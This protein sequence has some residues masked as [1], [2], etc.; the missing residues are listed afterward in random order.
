[1]TEIGNRLGQIYVYLGVAKC[2]LLQKEFDKVF[3][4]VFFS[5]YIFVSSTYQSVSVFLFNVVFS[6]SWLFAASAGPGR[7]NRKQGIYF[8]S[9]DDK[10]LFCVVQDLHTTSPCPANNVCIYAHILAVYSKGAL[11]V[12]G[13]LPKPGATGGAQGAG[14]EVSAVCR[15]AGALL[16]DVWGEHWG[17][18]PKAAGLTLFPHFPS[19]VGVLT[20][21]SLRY[22]QKCSMYISK[23]NRDDD[24]IPVHLVRCGF[25]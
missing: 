17:Q 7:C 22:I 6:G 2:W 18:G 8:I 3:F 11:S 16:W 20:M 4:I 10:T 9:A 23:F 12:W 5:G 1:M 15:G 14:G 25:P 21:Y 24:L 19:Q 13:D